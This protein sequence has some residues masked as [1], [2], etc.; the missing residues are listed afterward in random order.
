MTARREEEM[1]VSKKSWDRNRNVLLQVVEV[2]RVVAFR[3]GADTG[4]NTTVCSVGR[5]SPNNGIQPT[6]IRQNWAGGPPKSVHPCEVSESTRSH[7][8]TFSMYPSLLHMNYNTNVM[9]SG[10]LCFRCF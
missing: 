3:G 2:K 9:I 8:Q 10:I 6:R 4:W 1:W 5:S 7:L